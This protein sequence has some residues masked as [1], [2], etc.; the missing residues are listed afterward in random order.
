[1][2]EQLLEGSLEDNILTILVW[3]EMH[4]PVVALRVPVDL[5]STRPYQK[6]ADHA[7]E[8]LTKYNKPPG[9]HIRDL[10]EADLRRGDEGRFLEQILGAMDEL[11]VNLQPDFVL[12]QLDRFIQVR[13]LTQAVESAA[14]SLH[15]GDLEAAQEALSATS[16]VTKT[17]YPSVWLR[18]SDKWVSF[19]DQEEDSQ[20]SSGVGIFDERGISPRRG[21]LFLIIGPTGAG[22]S[23]W[24]NEM[25]KA[26]VILTHKNVLHITLEM[27]I[28]EVQQ[29]YTQSF[30]GMTE[31]EVISHRVPVYNHDTLG[32]FTTMTFNNIVP[33]SVAGIRKADLKEMLQPFQRRGQLLIQWFPTGM[34]TVPQLAAYLDMLDKT[35]GFKPDI[36]LLDYLDLMKTDS[37]DLR[38]STGVLTRELRGLAGMRNFALVTP[39]QGNRLSSTVRLV[40]ANMVAEDWSKIGT[41]D[42]VCTMSQTLDEKNIGIMRLLVAKARR[43]Q[44]KWIALI[45]QSYRTGQFCLDSEFMS[46]MVE[47]EV[48]RI[49]G[50]EE[51]PA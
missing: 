4:A 44:D 8:Y 26:N 9:V 34:L 45:T 3:S 24:L 19:L 41:A 1:M 31:S 17:D 22:K 23:W 32:R 35:Q 11:R 5:F 25:G 12:S 30:L 21:A 20:F 37:R 7:V 50:V 15:A 14:D 39:T 28:E 40:N 51:A 46:K 47:E 49:L 33:P 48:N 10:L 29:R 13:Q 42:F 43:R 6:I 36:V 16:L 2:P 27:D 18:D 38:V